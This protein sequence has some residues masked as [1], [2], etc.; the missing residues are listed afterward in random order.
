V[1]LTSA[2]TSAT[3]HEPGILVVCFREFCCFNLLHATVEPLKLLW[4]LEDIYFQEES[5]ASLFVKR[6]TIIDASKCCLWRCLCNLI[7]MSLGL[8][9]VHFSGCKTRGLWHFLK[10]YKWSPLRASET[11]GSIYYC[12]PSLQNQCVPKSLILVSGKNTVIG[13]ELLFTLNS[14]ITSTTTDHHICFNLLMYKWCCWMWWYLEDISTGLW[15]E[16]HK[17]EYIGPCGHGKADSTW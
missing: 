12:L 11:F 14:V 17:A 16:E 4:L 15:I 8:A 2:A 9:F 7:E 3:L 5:L 13:L 1:S 6:N 10:I